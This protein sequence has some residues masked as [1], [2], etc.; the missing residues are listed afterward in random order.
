MSRRILHILSA[1]LLLTAGV[2]ARGQQRYEPREG[3][4]YLYPEFTSGTLRTAGGTVITEGHYNICILDGSLHYVNAGTVMKADLHTVYSVVIGSQLD[5]RFFL[6]RAGEMVEVLAQEG[7]VYLFRRTR[8]DRNKYEKTDIGYGVSSATASSN[9]LTSMTLAG[10]S[11]VN[12][13]L[14]TIVDNAF[15]G[16]ILPLEDSYTFFVNGQEV[17]ASRNAFL[18]LEGLDPDKAKA[19]LKQ[20]KIR[21]H[22]EESLLKVAAYIAQQL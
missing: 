3:W 22:K 19:F 11:T 5:N 14:K 4:P 1:L 17:E 13:D 10:G 9:K 18:A 12:M 21:W 15:S 20:E 2:Q 8:L 7:G 6:H 16:E